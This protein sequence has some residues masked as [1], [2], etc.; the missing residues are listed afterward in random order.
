MGQSHLTDRGAHIAIAPLPH[1]PSYIVVQLNMHCCTQGMDLLVMISQ[2]IFSLQ[3]TVQAINR[4]DHISL[5]IGRDS[6]DL[7]AQLFRPATQPGYIHQHINRIQSVVYIHLRSQCPSIN[8]DIFSKSRR[9]GFEKRNIYV[10]CE[11]L[12]RRRTKSRPFRGR[13]DWKN[14]SFMDGH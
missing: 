2:A 10:I 3:H 11:H 9:T 13:R 5:D 6:G 12:R 14:R 8:E 7:T 1:S 4:F